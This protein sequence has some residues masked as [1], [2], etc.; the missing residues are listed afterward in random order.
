MGRYANAQNLLTQ[1]ARFLLEKDEASAIIDAMEATVKAKWYETARREGV[2][3]AD[4][5]RISGAFAYDGFRI[6]S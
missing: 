6:E 3:D 5:D 4:C 1:C 2:S